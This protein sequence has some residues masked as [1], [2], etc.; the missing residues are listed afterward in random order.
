M[1]RSFRGVND[2]Q[3]TLNWILLIYPEAGIKL[4]SPTVIACRRLRELSVTFSNSLVRL[5][6]EPEYEHR[7]RKPAK[8]QR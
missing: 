5:L 7:T 8:V 2:D 3:P 4:R 1:V 6:P